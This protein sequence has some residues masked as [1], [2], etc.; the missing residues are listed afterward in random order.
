MSLSRA[1]SS[2]P[3]GWFS[4]GA[5]AHYALERGLIFALLRL[6]GQR[7]PEMT[8]RLPAAPQPLRGQAR[9][10]V[11]LGALGAAAERLSSQVESCRWVTALRGS[12]AGS[13]HRGHVAG[14]E[15][16]RPPE[17]GEGILQGVEGEVACPHPVT[18]VGAIQLGPALRRERRQ[19][20]RPEAADGLPV[21]VGRLDVEGP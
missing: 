2:S 6:K 1:S 17:V 13:E 16:E 19:L 18:G 14:L 20:L 4:S 9:E 21:R 7:M 8:E 11:G 5:A 10:V 3:G 15:L 12:D